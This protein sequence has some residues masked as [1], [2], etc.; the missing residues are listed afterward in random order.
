MSAS[1]Y[2]AAAV[3]LLVVLFIL[4]RP[5]L[6][7]RRAD[8]TSRQAMNAAIYREQLRELESDVAEGSLTQAAFE[9]AQLEL[10]R[11]LLNESADSEQPAALPVGGGRKT[12]IALLVILPLVSI[13]LYVKL[14]TPDALKPG[15]AHQVSAGDMDKMVEGL[16][17]RLEKNPDDLRGWAMLA[18]TYKAMKRFDD[19][20]KAFDK[21]GDAINDDPDLL[22]N[23][24]DLLAVQARGNLE[25]RPLKMIEK[26]LEL[27]P[28]HQM[29]L[30]LAGTAAY[31]RRDFTG[32]VAYWERLLKTLPPGSEDAQGVATAIERL[33]KEHNLGPVAAKSAGKKAEA[34]SVAGTPVPLR[35]RVELSKAAKG[36]FAA[37]DTVFVVARLAEGGKMP[38]AAKRIT[39]A[40][41]PYDFVLDDSL[42]MM[43]GNKLS[44]AGQV[45]VEARVSKSGDVK[46]NSGDW[47]G[48]TAPIKP[49][50]QGVKI[51]IDQQ[52]P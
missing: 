37:G 36:K 24:A 21:L 23:Y 52:V 16:A 39:V 19:A 6:R 49:N 7:P 20:A 8:Q 33:R 2:I 47:F 50:A 34:K 44:E 3:L 43:S 29:S 38:L 42:A 32:A 25:G 48:R 41:L 35:G 40:N 12:A 18:R 14:G 46:M 30:S 28:E 5:L 10:Q 26:A 1:F 4:L 27:D 51:T 13:A 15:L 22:A 11:R 45:V 9:E 17:A 31:D